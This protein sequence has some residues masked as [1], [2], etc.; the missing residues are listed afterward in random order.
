VIE[1]RHTRHERQPVRAQPVL[2]E[3]VGRDR[4]GDAVKGPDHLPA[5]VD[6]EHGASIQEPLLEVIVDRIGGEVDVDAV[7]AVEAIGLFS[8]AK[9][10]HAQAVDEPTLKEK[11]D[12]ARIGRHA[13]TKW[14]G[15]AAFRGCRDRCVMWRAGSCGVSSSATHDTG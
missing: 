14:W 5:A 10:D 6:G 4:E 9:R 2:V 15:R 8:A 12:I 1:A 11:V 13:S 3:A 7:D